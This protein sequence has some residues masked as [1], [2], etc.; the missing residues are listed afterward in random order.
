[1]NN[2]EYLN[3]LFES[4][5]PL[6]IYKAK[7]G[8]DVFTDFSEKINIT[9]TNIARF[10][11]KISFKQKKYNKFFDGY[12][13]FFG[14]KILCELINIK[15][16]K[17]KSNNFPK[18][19]FYKPQ[20]VIKIRNTIKVYSTIKNFRFLKDLKPSKQTLYFSKKFKVNFSLK[21]YSKIFDKFLKK[22]KQGETY[23]IKI[24][25]KYSSKSHINAI[26]FF[27]KLMKVN[28]SPEAFLIRDKNY[29]IV[30]C[31]PETLFE[32]RKN[33]IFTKPIA[34]TMKKT[35]KTS[36]LKAINFFKSNEKETKEHNMIVDMER[37]DLSRVCKSGTVKISKL[38]YVQEYKDLYH[39]ITEISGIL[40]KSKTLLDII[41]ALMPGGSVIGCPK[42]S[43]LNLL[44][45]QEKYNRNIYTGSFG[46]IKS[47]LDM[48]FNVI[49]RTIL[50]YK[51]VS[52]IFVASGVVVGSTA[53]KEYQENYIKAKS[54]LDLFS[55]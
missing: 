12:V 51:G 52:E 47:N 23:Q 44:N 2:K 40:D 30:S 6:I 24:C 19:I 39:Y 37:N 20:T 48:K 41:K 11:K 28:S 54:L 42:I 50:N 17:Q 45:N 38:K 21:Q 46:Y 33:R 32:K 49:I 43:T 16:P 7:N 5:K 9:N 18:S 15:I 31:S 29:S 8:F 4:D 22:I 34:G 35:S 55:Q 36:K 3:R 13:G 10:L 14:Y 26:D 27:W 25:Q 53:K 1:M